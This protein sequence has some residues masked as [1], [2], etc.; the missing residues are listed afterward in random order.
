MVA[1]MCLASLAI[2]VAHARLAK[3]QLQTAA[4]AAV[5]SAIVGF[6][7]DITTA[8][9]N[10]VA[11]ARLNTVD[12]TPVVLNTNTD[13]EFG[14]WDASAKTFTAL[15]GVAQNTATAIRITAR[16]T[17]ATNNAVS[18]AFGGLIGKST[19]DVQAQAIAV[20][21]TYGFSVV[22]ISSLTT[23][24]HDHPIQIDSWNSAAGSYGVFPM[25]SHGNCSSNGN[26]N[27]VSS[28]KIYGSC[29]AGTGMTLSSSGSTVTGATADLKY[30]LNYPAPDPGNAATTN[31]NAQL[32]A[33]YFSSVTR[34]FTIPKGTTLTIPG[35]TY[36][37][38]NIDWEAATI[39]F[40]G[41]A[42]FYI[43]GTGNAAHPS[44]G[45]WTFN[46]LIT[47]YNN[48]PKNLKFEVVNATNV[49]Y[50]FDQACY[51]VLYAPLSTVTTWGK[52][53]DYG[54]VVGN[55]LNMYVGWHV[56]ETL[57]GAGV[58]GK[59]SMVQ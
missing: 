39:T 47:T 10:A 56:D 23:A 51:A 36:Y 34:D 50:D 46:N 8:Q 17:A 42:V 9:N 15:S 16:R 6:A 5:R 59:V 33:A 45:L 32:P 20:S 48:L 55:V 44:N 24:V 1:F 40:T 49:Q 54:A 14:T 12:N 4:D 37:V 3:R 26:I 58:T 22:G 2:D 19:C 38:N 30:T 43:T 53:D 31:N 28:T 29:Q 13:V 27:L 25:N 21:S 52:A 11:A 18:L 35:G 57:T 7:V 41:P